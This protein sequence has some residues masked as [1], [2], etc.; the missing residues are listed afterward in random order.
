[1]T[2]TQNRPDDRRVTGG[3]PAT[4]TVGEK[5]GFTTLGER[6]WELTV[7][8]VSHTHDAALVDVTFTDDDGASSN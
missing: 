2:G 7:E 4:W 3:V 8:P 5:Y 6:D 1:M